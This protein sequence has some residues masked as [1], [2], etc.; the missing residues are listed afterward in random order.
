MAHRIGAVLD[1]RP[2]F[3]ADHGEQARDD[4]PRNDLP[5]PHRRSV[6]TAENP[7]AEMRY[8]SNWLRR[9]LAGHSH[10]TIVGSAFS[11]NPRGPPVSRVDQGGAIH[12]GTSHCS[13]AAK[14]LA[15]PLGPGT[16]QVP[17]LPRALA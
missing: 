17:G 13:T 7:P 8:A 1:G 4:A 5:A 11:G 16:A 9:S 15:V 10:P 3:R 12:G 14:V 2:L 6:V